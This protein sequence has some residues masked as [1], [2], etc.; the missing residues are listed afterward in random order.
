MPKD[1]FL[2]LPSDKREAITNVLLEEFAN[3]EYKLVSISAI[4]RKANIAK[5]SFY[6]YFDDKAD[7]FLYLFQ[8]AMQEKMQF[9]NSIPA[10]KEQNDLF[11][12]LRWMME[13]GT[14]FEFSNPNYA[15]I[16]YRAVFEDVPLPAETKA[17][18]EEGS[19]GYFKEQLVQGIAAGEIAPDVDPDIGAF[20]LESTF[21][22]VGRHLMAQA[23]VSPAELLEQG[24]AAFASEDMQLALDQVISILE[25]GFKAK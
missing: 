14:K 4:V 13:A 8:L 2:N 3:Q 16:G 21:N 20:I 23:A 9:M 10:D 17:L 1:T 15:Q 6:Q 7:A 18:I 19:R 22:N 5:G 11:A 25:R 24:A 12:N